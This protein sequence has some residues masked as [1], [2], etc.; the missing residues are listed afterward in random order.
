[1]SSA[2]SSPCTNISEDDDEINVVDDE[3]G[4][5]NVQMEAAAV[6]T[7]SMSICEQLESMVT[8]YATILKIHAVLLA[9][10]P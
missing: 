4:A 2:S 10:E 7:A 6:P 1:M 5:D 3:D 8:R 9:G